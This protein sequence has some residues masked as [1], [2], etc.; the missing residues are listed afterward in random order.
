MTLGGIGQRDAGDRP[1]DVA[2]S[3][4]TEQVLHNT[5]ESE[6]GTTRLPDEALPDAAE[7]D[8]EEAVA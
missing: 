8:A 5:H 2:T 7:D 4:L 1:R 6:K 3:P